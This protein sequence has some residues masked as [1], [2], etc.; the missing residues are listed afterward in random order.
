MMKNREKGL[1]FTTTIEK[2]LAASTL[3]PK[4]PEGRYVTW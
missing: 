2:R 1:L 4:F 3:Q